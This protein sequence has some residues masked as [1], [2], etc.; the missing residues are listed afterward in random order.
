M[1]KS[2]E[3]QDSTQP[4]FPPFFKTV[5]IIKR[6]GSN[7]IHST[8]RKLKIIFGERKLL[9]K[10]K[11][12]KPSLWAEKHRVVPS[13]S[14]MPGRWKNTTTPYL[15]GIMDASF[16]PSV[17]TI[18]ICAA[19]Q[20]GKS[21][22]VNN[23]VGYIADRRPGN[24]LYNYPD[25]LTAKENSRDRIQP[26]FNDSPKLKQ[27]LTGY[28][29]DQAALRINL[30]HMRIYMAWAT[31]PARLGNKPIPYIVNDEVDKY[32]PYTSKKE[33]TPEDLAEKRTRTFAGKK[34]IW[35]ISTPTTESGPIWKALTQEA[36]FVFDFWVRC[37]HCNGQQKMSFGQ[38][39]WPENERDPRVV[40]SKG[41][42]WYECEKCNAKWDDE[43]RNRAVRNGDWFSRDKKLALFTVLNSQ[44]PKA[45]GFHIPSWLS[46]FVS[47]S[48]VASNFLKSLTDKTKLRDFKNNDEAI[49]WV[50]YVET[51]SE[52]T[53]M[54]LKDD[55][56]SGIVPGGGVIAAITAGVDTQDNGFY[57]EIRAWGYGMIKES[58][59]VR[60]G[61]VES[62][63]AL[64][65]IL[66]QDVYQDADGKKYVV[67]LVV[68]D[69]MGHKTAEVYDFCRENKGRIIALQGKDRMA[70]PFSYSNLEYYPGGKKPIPGGL[71]LLQVNTTYYKNNLANILTISGADPGA[72]HMHSDVTE[73]YARQMTAE[74]IDDS[75]IWIPKT[76]SRANHY[77]DC[78]VYNL[79]A[80]DVLGV[81]YW[82][83]P[84]NRPKE[85]PQPEPKSQ[86]PWIE[87]KSGWLNR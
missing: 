71:K 46:R 67:N 10:K 2:L 40:K 18:I 42:A 82:P 76:E 75:G 59:Q 32:P 34:K 39:K 53:I 79:A 12:I 77:W 17:E 78:A 43:D 62:F 80:H 8:K 85:K 63:E 87:K 19:P 27:Y 28:Q 60:F 29:D 6:F 47:L 25:E 66:W 20:T 24:V 33:A 21:D 23:C 16:F 7:F 70:Q 54:A 84:D 72:F 61:F 44:K 86:K 81:K 83:L 50:E 74:Y 35:K 22:C 36:E 38:I 57:Y 73:D 56:P 64:T 48:E 52:S 45:I 58:W 55:R 11:Y 68:Q 65:K 4:D 14:T 31:S 13:D 3:I 5:H 41:L 37:P 49:P 51:G 26:M 69:A 15:A 1:T 30:K 9:E